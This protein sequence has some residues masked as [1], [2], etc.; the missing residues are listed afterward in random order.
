M[1]VG[2]SDVLAVCLAPST[3]NK[4]P[5][6]VDGIQ[7]CSQRAEKQHCGESKCE[8]IRFSGTGSSIFVFVF[9]RKGNLPDNHV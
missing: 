4:L 1:A 7:G 2:I 5:V 9:G 3:R 6:Q 8:G